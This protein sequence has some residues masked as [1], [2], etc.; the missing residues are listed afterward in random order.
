M[1]TNLEFL[2]KALNVILDPLNKLCLIL[3]DGTTD[4][5]THKQGVEAG[6]NTEHFIGILG[7]AQLVPEPSCDAGLCGG[8]EREREVW[9]HVFMLQYHI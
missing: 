1:M 5:G 9:L 4:V 6:E 7:S 3:S 8:R 2:M